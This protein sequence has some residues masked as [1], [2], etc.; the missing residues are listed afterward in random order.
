MEEK[1][2]GLIEVYAQGKVFYCKNIEEVDFI[3]EHFKGW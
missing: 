2:Y 3:L 1:K